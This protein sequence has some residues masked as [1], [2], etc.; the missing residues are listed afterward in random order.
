MPNIGS[1]LKQEISRLCRREIRNATSTLRKA[2]TAARHDVAA[3]KRRVAEM[4]RHTSRMGKKI[5]NEQAIESHGGAEPSF[6]FVAKGF[7]TH[8]D[9]L[10]LSQPQAAKLLGVSQQS[11][12]NW[13]GKV[14]TPR[15]QL[16][17]KI[18]WFRK[19]GKRLAHELIRTPGM[20][21][22]VGVSHRGRQPR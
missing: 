13:E 4:E 10:G 21:G 9:R 8:R 5:T 16:L 2:A 1:I 15:R 12:Y 14:S 20:K 3:L 19:L 7:R 11:I 22:K 6:R 17:G 18:A